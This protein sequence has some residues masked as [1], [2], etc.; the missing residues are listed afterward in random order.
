MRRLV[1][2]GT[3]EEYGALVA[4]AGRY[5]TGHRQGGDAPP[6]AAHRLLRD[7]RA[8]DRL[9]F[10]RRLAGRLAREEFGRCRRRG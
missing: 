8:L 3:T 1:W 10:G 7:Q 2:H 5:C 4:A 6:C 9:L